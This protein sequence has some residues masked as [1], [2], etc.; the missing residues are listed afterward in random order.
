MR[1]G[2]SRRDLL[3]TGAVAGAA[4][5]VGT[6]PASAA[7]P[8]QFPADIELGKSTFKN[9]AGALD[10][11]G[12]WTA[13][14]RDS[15]GVVRAVNWAHRNGW[16]V[17]AK[18]SMHGWSPLTVTSHTRPAGRLLLVDTRH[19]RHLSLHH[20]HGGAAVTMGAGTPLLEALSFLEAHDLGW[21]SVPS[22]GDPTIGGALAIGAHGAALPADGEHPVPGNT[23]GSLSNLVLSMTA[24][25]WDERHASYRLRTFHRHETEMAALLVHIGRAFITEVTLRAGRNQNLRCVSRT[26]IPLTELMAPPGS[27]GETFAKFVAEGG[28]VEAI[29]FPF[30]EKPWLKVWSVAPTRPASSR[31][32]SSPYN[33]V[34]TDAV[35]IPIEV[36]A[37]DL[38]RG[39]SELTVVFSQAEYDVA[40]AGLAALDANDLWG[41]SKDTQFYIESSTV[42]FDEN[43]YGIACR[44][45]DIQ[46]ILHM[47]F[48]FYLDLLD[49]HR[50]AGRFPMNGPVEVRACGIDDPA[51]AGI[52]HAQPSAIAGTGQRVDHPEWDTVV[53]LNPLTIHGTAG[54]YQFGRD[55]EQWIV[56][57]FDGRWAAARPEWSKGWAFSARA[58]WDDKAMLQHHIPRI[59]SAGRHRDRGF[60]WAMDRLN[61]LDPHRVFSNGFLDRFAT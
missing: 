47:F 31:A 35:P 48:T 17:R 44:R 37:A 32:T 43:G 34:F 58:S 3:Y 45:R 50:A 22:T 52:P 23:Y 41:P 10:I 16:R 8:P 24:V 33:Y 5:A 9:W 55:V 30:T 59:V 19:L 11:P 21:T 20:D 60:R 51:E 18:G 6:R 2:L 13:V 15:H 40:V 39:N 14:P 29:W 12:L 1:A 36:P 54:Q 57:T 49:R 56:R 27:K 38:I 7:T 28:R 25:V 46:R 4:I 26:D 53:W 42:R 61:D